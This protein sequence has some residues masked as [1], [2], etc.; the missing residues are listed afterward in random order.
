MRLRFAVL[1]IGGLWRWRGWI[2]FTRCRATAYLRG[3][4]DTRNTSGDA[5]LSRLG[6]RDTVTAAL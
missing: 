4:D 3:P 6:A 5:P 1:L 2:S